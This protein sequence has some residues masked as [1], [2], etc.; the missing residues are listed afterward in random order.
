MR[1]FYSGMAKAVAAYARGERINIVNNA[2]KD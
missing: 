1:R 2:R